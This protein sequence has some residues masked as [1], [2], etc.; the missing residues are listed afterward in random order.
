[1][2][3]YNGISLW[4]ASDGAGFDSVIS[5]NIIVVATT[6]GILVVNHTNVKVNNNSVLST[7]NGSGVLIDRCTHFIANGNNIKA[8]GTGIRVQTCIKGVISNNQVNGCGNR[9]IYATDTGTGCT[10]ISCT[11]NT[12][13]DNTGRPLETVNNADYWC[14]T[15]NVF[16]NNSVLAIAMVG[17]N[18]V[19]ANNIVV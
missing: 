5:D 17:T 10:S 7:T 6:H 13:V 12:I 15:G 16:R 18:N 19:N 14:V 1:M 8:A 11:G 3:R 9:R 4:V 2:R